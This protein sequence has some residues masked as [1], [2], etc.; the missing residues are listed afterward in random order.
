MDAAVV[1][2]VVVAFRIGAEG[3][4]IR[5]GE[6]FFHLHPVVFFQLDLNEDDTSFFVTVESFLG[7]FL[8]D[9]QLDGYDRL[10]L[11]IEKSDVGMLFAKGVVRRDGGYLLKQILGI[12]P[13]AIGTRPSDGK[14]FLLAEVSLQ[15]SYGC[16]Q[17]EMVKQGFA[18][19][20]RFRFLEVGKVRTLGF[21]FVSGNDAVS[22]QGAG[23]GLTLFGFV[24]VQ[25]PPF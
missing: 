13:V 25:D 2:L 10:S 16:L 8:S 11:G 5:L 17:E 1:E 9:E 22:T 19:A 7:E 21:S 4:G 12:G 23:V 20:P 14:F 24:D 3:N 18:A 15:E 6:L